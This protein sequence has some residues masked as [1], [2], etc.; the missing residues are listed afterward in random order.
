VLAALSPPGKF[1]VPISVRGFVDPR[2]ITAE[3]EIEKRNIIVFFNI[4][5]HITLVHGSFF[6]RYAL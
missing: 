5:K 1:L 6:S 3:E 2:A 4:R